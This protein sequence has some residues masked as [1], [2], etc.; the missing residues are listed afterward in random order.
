M[1][2]PFFLLVMSGL[3]LSQDATQWNGCNEFW[4]ELL[5]QGKTDQTLAFVQNKEV[6]SFG[7]KNP[8]LQMRDEGN[9]LMMGKQEPLLKLSKWTINCTLDLKVACSKYASKMQCYHLGKQADNLVFGQHSDKL[10]IGRESDALPNEPDAKKLS[11]GQPSDR[12]E[13]CSER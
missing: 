9:C 5:E 6:L 7:Q 4:N 3:I 10:S 1:W 11:F 13:F 2:L 8:L 12:L